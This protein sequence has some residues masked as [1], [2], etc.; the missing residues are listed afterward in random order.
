MSLLGFFLG[1]A[2]LPE[3]PKVDLS[4]IVNWFVAGMTS[5]VTSNATVIITGGLAVAAITGAVWAIKKFGKK[6]VKG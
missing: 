2:T 5:L 3:F 1:S 6:A 4:A